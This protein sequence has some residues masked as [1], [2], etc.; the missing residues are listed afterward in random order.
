MPN[1]MNQPIPHDWVIAPIAWFIV[2]LGIQAN[3]NV[4]FGGF[5]LAIACAA[6]VAKTTRDPREVWLIFL[7]AVVLSLMAVIAIEYWVLPFPIPLG[8]GLAGFSS[9]WVVQIVVNM[10][11]R[12]ED[13]SPEAAD[14]MINKILPEDKD[15]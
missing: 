6:I 4:I 2:A 7:S 13:R 8:M 10:L 1:N 14:R 12:A 5:S 3:V 9:K 11:D 15:K